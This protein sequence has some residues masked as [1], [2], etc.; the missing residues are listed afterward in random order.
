MGQTYDTIHIA[1]V[2]RSI[3]QELKLT[4]ESAKSSATISD[5][6]ELF[7]DISA[8]LPEATHLV[9]ILQCV[10]HAQLESMPRELPD[11]IQLVAA[12]CSTESTQISSDHCIRLFER[13]DE[14]SPRELIVATVSLLNYSPFGI[15]IQDLLRYLSARFHADQVVQ[16][17][18]L[19]ETLGI[20]ACLLET[21]TTNIEYKYIFSFSFHRPFINKT[22]GVGC[23]FGRR[24][25]SFVGLVN[26]SASICRRFAGHVSINSKPNL[27]RLV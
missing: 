12:Y 3:L 21:R 9:A 5:L 24:C 20:P 4:T 17:P 6:Q 10:D 11:N 15:S 25:D 7:V 16:L 8:L 23:G 13:L 27:W 1:D 2:H 26:G 22:Y 14:E 18:R 19:I